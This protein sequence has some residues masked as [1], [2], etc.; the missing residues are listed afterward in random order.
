MIQE[1]IYQVLLGPRV[2]EKS[3]ALSEAGQYVFKVATD[4][5]KAEIKT[6]VESLLEVDV[7]NVRTL[8]VKGKKKNFGRRQGKRKDWKKA[9]VRLA[10]GQSLENVVEA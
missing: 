10:E 8:N 4:A 2:S 1:R 9:Y 5:T 6:A 3:V 7:V